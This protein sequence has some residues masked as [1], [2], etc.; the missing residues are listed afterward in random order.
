[1]LTLKKDKQAVFINLK[2][3]VLN[4]GLQLK[5]ICLADSQ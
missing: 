3:A 4:P 2:Q 5:F 1:L